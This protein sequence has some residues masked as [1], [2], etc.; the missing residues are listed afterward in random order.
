MWHLYR[1]G[2]IFLSYLCQPELSRAGLPDFVWLQ[3]REA[4]RAGASLRA[5]PKCPG[6]LDVQFFFLEF[7]RLQGFAE[8]TVSALQAA[9][10]PSEHSLPRVNR[11][12]LNIDSISSPDWAIKCFIGGSHTSAGQSV[13]SD[14]QQGLC[15]RESGVPGAGMLWCWLRGIQGASHKS[16][17]YLKGDTFGFI[18]KNAEHPD[19]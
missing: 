7:T 2:L 12:A 10:E 8:T 5:L 11:I 9:P 18:R 4:S 1:V 13:S 16:R 17:D 15:N 14:F 19:T 6:F 3:G